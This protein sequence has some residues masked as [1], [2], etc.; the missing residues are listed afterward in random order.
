MFVTQEPV[1]FDNGAFDLEVCIP[2]NPGYKA[3]DIHFQLQRRRLR[4][5]VS[6]FNGGQASL[7][8]EQ[9]WDACDPKRFTWALMYREGMC[10]I[11][12][13]VYKADPGVHWLHPFRSSVPAGVEPI[14]PGM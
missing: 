1:S 11:Q 5:G 9:P 3:R 12:V 7:N 4:I 2:V 6:A 13:T 10:C 8:A 14:H